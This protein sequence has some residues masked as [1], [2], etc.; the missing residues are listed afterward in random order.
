MISWIW[1]AYGI[2]VLYVGLFIAEVLTTKHKSRWSIISEALL[3]LLC[4]GLFTVLVQP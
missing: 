3:V 4:V 1:I 2:V